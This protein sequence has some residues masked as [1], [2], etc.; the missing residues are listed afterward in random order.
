MP[1][2]QESPEKLWQKSSHSG[3]V[4]YV[5]TGGYYARF[6]VPGKLVWQSLKTT[7]LSVAVLRLGDLKKQERTKVS[8]TDRVAGGKLTL[9]DAARL[10]LEAVEANRN[11][12][13]R[14]KAYYREVLKRVV[15]SW[16][17]WE[18]TQAGKVT[19]SDCLVWANKMGNCSPSV[20]NHAVGLL[21]RILDVAVENG[22]SYSNPAQ[23]IPK[24]KVRQKELKLPEP[25]RF[26]RFVASIESSGSGWSKPCAN[27][28]LFLAYGGFRKSE[29]ANITWADVDYGVMQIKVTGDP[30]SGTKNGETRLVPI[31]PEMATLL[32]KLR[33][34]APSS[35]A[36]DHVMQVNECQ[37]AMDR[38]ATQV[39]MFRITHHDLRHLF[40]TRCIEAGVDIPTVSRWLG[41]KDGGALCMRTYGHLRN[42]HS[43]E[44][45]QKVH[46]GAHPA[47]EAKSTS[48]KHAPTSTDPT[49][50][51]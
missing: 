24:A 47:S 46:F 33:S 39:G 44:M 32:K 1:P 4:R 22:A 7:R 42:F 34:E 23:S 15:S 28:V 45:A 3:L 30:V 16:P 6:R 38:A 13:A 51:Q 43:A 20:F 5:P 41:H 18:S 21:R 19:K 29:A 26:A 36:A 2:D 8:A 27:L 49:P 48:E 10:H 35:T 31:I 50:A 12:K 17:G 9:A 25:E 37:K 40:A 14:T 11:I